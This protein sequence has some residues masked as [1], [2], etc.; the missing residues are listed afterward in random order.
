MH[1]ELASGRILGSM[2]SPGHWIHVT[3]VGEIYVASLT[4]NVLR[5]SPERVSQSVASEE[6]LPPSNP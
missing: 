5:W 2:E 4:G 6:R 1:V 3:P